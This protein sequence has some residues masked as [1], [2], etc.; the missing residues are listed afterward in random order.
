MQNGERLRIKKMKQKIIIAVVLAGGLVSGQRVLADDTTDQINALRQQIDAL[1]QKVRVLERQKE[2]DTEGCAAKGKET[3]KIV[4]G[5]NGLSV[6]SGDSNFVFQLHG[7]I[8]ADSR[9]FFDDQ[10]NHGKD[11]QGNDG[12]IL[13]RARPIFSGTGYKDFYFVFM[14]DFGGST[15]QIFD[16]YVN[17]HYAPWLQ[18]R[19]GKFK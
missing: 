2:L 16:G 4:V 1:D 14:P 12:F 3:P 7:L 18:V 8:Q 13:R 17:Y 10:D 15:V 19:A 6:A 11:I 9:T 5:N